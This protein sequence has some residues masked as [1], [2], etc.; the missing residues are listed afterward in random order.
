[1]GILLK[2]IEIASVL[3][4]HGCN[5]LR[6]AWVLAWDVNNIF[7]DERAPPLLSSYDDHYQTTYQRS[8][9]MWCLT[10][11]VTQIICSRLHFIHFAQA[12]H[13][14]LKTY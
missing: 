13:G 5:D 14:L 7:L 2:L 10:L 12:E 1:M 6:L 4:L 9:I 8:G 11:F 3:A